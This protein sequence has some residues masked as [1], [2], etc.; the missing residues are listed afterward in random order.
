[1]T[2]WPLT[3]SDFPT[4]QIFH[5]FHDLYTELDFHRIMSGF[6][7]A[8]A[9]GVGSQQERLPFRTPG[10]V[11]PPPFGTCLCSN[12]WDQISRLF[13]FFTRLF[14]LNTP[15]YFLD[16]ALLDIS[17]WISLGTFSILLFVKL[18]ACLIELDFIFFLFLDFVL[19][20]TIHLMPTM[21]ENTSLKETIPL[22]G[23]SV[24]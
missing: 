9:T 1:M 21:F 15:R 7:G 2:F 22:Y 18:H 11:P 20:I 16:F 17:S 8:F 12:C 10:S 4:D 24:Y 14:T 3:N 5:Q 19:K 6:H 13:H 23:R